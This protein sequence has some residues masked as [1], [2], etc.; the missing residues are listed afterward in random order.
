MNTGSEK[1]VEYLNRALKHK[2]AAVS[3]V[4]A[5]FPAAGRLGGQET[6]LG[7]AQDLHRGDVPCRRS[8][9][10][11]HLSRGASKPA[12]LEPLRIGETVREVLDADLRSE[13][14]ARA[15]F[16][17]ARE[18][19][20]TESD[21]VSMNLMEALITNEEAQIDFIETQMD[22]YGQIGEAKFIIL[23]AEPLRVAD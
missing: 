21:Y 5:A 22:L 9:R 10:A 11:D 15:L 1:V 18:V 2:L 16:R 19:C 8:D 23:N 6:G 17:E 3:Q 12:D 7:M 14:L 20:R 4:L 13:Y